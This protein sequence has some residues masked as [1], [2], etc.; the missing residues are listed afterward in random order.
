MTILVSGTPVNASAVEHYTNW[1]RLMNSKSR[2]LKN[3]Q[4]I[5]LVEHT[6]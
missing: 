6:G 4:V 3:T 2:T 5:Y 1:S